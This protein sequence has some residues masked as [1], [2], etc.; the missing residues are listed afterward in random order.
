MH[1][2]TLSPQFQVIASYD[3]APLAARLGSSA[4]LKSICPHMGNQEVPLALDFLI[5][6]GLADSHDKVRT[7]QG[8]SVAFTVVHMAWNFF[9]GKGVTPYSMLAN[10]MQHLMRNLRP[11]VVLV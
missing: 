2:L 5:R 7:R 8:A 11:C 1:A 6:Y 3:S 4:A 9:G 10:G